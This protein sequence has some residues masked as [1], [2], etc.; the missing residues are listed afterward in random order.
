ML[1]RCDSLDNAPG[2]PAAQSVSRREPC[3]AGDRY[4]C[5]ALV[6]HALQRP[7]AGKTHMPQPSNPR[8]FLLTQLH[9]LHSFWPGI[10]DGDVE[11]VHDARVATRRARAALPFVFDAPEAAIKELRRIGRALGRV[12]ELDVTDLLLTSLEQKA[13]DTAAAIAVLRHDLRARLNRERRRMIKALD[14]HPRTIIRAIEKGDRVGRL[15]SLWKSWRQGVRDGV[16][17]HAADVRDAIERASAVYMP[18]RSH[19]ARIEIK[20]LRYAVELAIATGLLRHTEVVDQFKKAQD[21]LGVLHDL[22]VLSVALDESELPDHQSAQRLALASVINAELARVQ[23]KYART[24]ADVIAA[25][26][27]CVREIDASAADGPGL[28]A[29]ALV[30]VPVLAAWYIGAPGEERSTQVRVPDTD[31]PGPDA[32]S[33]VAFATRG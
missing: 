9:Q 10:H 11:S 26:D 24:R 4:I 32:A 16:R 33:D 1:T 22:H 25:C 29:A 14:R 13:P 27:A 12:R 15:S 18:N 3:A 6:A 20:K 8:Q 23:A 31:V 30:A 28:A 21:R 7:D 19:A 2:P 17:R 5:N